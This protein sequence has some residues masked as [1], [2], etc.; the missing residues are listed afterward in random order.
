MKKLM[1]WMT[2][3]ALFAGSALHAQNITGTWQGTLNGG[4]PLRL[5]IK[6]SLDDD[7]L[8]ATSYSI[9][10]GGQPIPVSAITRDGSTVKMTV[11]MINGS[12]E[13][14]LS[15]DGNSITGT[16]TQG[17]PLPLNLTRA[18][19]ETEWT[20]PEPPAPPKVMAAT[21]QRFL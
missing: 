9:D 3:F 1:L 12:Y 2:A 14:K 11:A 4:Q 5:V 21:I 17:A 19:P 10:Q 13:G 8:K 7:K 6:I 15:A 18:T 20:I 16:W